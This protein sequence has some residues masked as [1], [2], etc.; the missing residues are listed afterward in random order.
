M[1]L[2]RINRTLAKLVMIAGLV[3]TVGS[4]VLM[5]VSGTPSILMLAAFGTVAAAYAASRLGETE[6]SPVQRIVE[7][8]LAEAA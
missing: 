3:F 7:Q 6:P 2:E 4:V 5:V 1:R 8:P